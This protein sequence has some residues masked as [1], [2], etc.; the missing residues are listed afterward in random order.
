MQTT[1]C[2]S[3]SDRDVQ[4]FLPAAWRR[5]VAP[6]RV[7]VK[8][9]NPEYPENA[10]RNVADNKGVLAFLVGS[11]GSA[12]MP[13]FHLTRTDFADFEAPMRTAVAESMVAAARS[14]GRRVS[15]LVTQPFQC[16]VRPATPWLR[17]YRSL[18][19]TPSA[20]RAVR[21]HTRE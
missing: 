1:F 5:C 3:R 6:L 9:A 15:Q 13:S 7:A 17:S 8:L 10:R 2:C 20:N 19:A 18:R 12:Y 16:S 4:R 14:G 21:H 11:G